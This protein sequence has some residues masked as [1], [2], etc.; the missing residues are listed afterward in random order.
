[1]MLSKSHSLKIMYS[2]SIE[3]LKTYLCA[4]AYL[5]Q[6]ELFDSEHLRDGLFAFAYRFWL[7]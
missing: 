5:F 6:D 3:D 7:K 2:T 1:M 4:Q